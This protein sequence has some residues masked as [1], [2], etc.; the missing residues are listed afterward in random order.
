MINGSSARS[1]SGEPA[2]F[3]ESSMMAPVVSGIPAV[4]TRDP[5]MFLPASTALTVA[6][7][8]HLTGGIAWTLVAGVL[9]GLVLGFLGAGGTVVALP[10]LLFLAGLEPHRTLGTNAFGVFL[11]AG[12]LFAWQSRRL[13][14]PLKQGLLFAGFGGPGIYLGA[15]LGLL[16]PGQ[17]LIFLLGLVLFIVA[18]W[19]MY[20]SFHQASPATNTPAAST[21][22]AA[23]TDP[24]PPPPGPARIAAIA[25]AAFGVG[26]TA[27]FF[28]IGGGFMIVPALMLVGGLELPLAAPVALLPIAAFAGVVGAEYWLAGEIRPVWSA[29]ML[30]AGI[31]AGAAGIWL[32]HRISKVVLLR[33]FAVFLVALGV[34]IAWPRLAPYLAHHL[35]A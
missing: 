28:G 14:L 33:V 30:L 20:L 11:I 18:G 15:H 4:R 10:V 8:P 24:P 25:C 9:A 13:H 22:P 12:L 34:Y 7:A 19:M 1:A 2:R 6:A 29:V 23:Q 27:G 3:A 26:L 35:T 17:K 31:P 5:S 32:S 16:Y 21:A